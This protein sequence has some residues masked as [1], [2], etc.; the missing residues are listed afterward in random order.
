MS[1]SF[2]ATPAKFLADEIH[3]ADF[4][5]FSTQILRAMSAA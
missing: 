5:T 2:P 4:N 3:R 1:G